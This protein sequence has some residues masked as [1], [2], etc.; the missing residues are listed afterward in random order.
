MLRWRAQQA[1]TPET[2]LGPEPL[3]EAVQQHLLVQDLKQGVVQE[4]AFP[5]GTLHKLV[6]DDRNDQVEHDEVDTKDEGDT[7]DG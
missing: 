6:N 5:A 4:E 2:H 1:T 3:E 7:V